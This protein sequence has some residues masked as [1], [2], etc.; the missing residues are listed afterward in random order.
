MFFAPCA[1]GAGACRLLAGMLCQDSFVD[2][3]VGGSPGTRSSCEECSL[4][5]YLKVLNATCFASLEALVV[6]CIFKCRCLEHMNKY[7]MQIF[8]VE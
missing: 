1:G 2:F 6:A 4:V 3:S 5:S 8:E 7:Y